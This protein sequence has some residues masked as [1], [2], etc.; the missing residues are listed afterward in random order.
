MAWHVT[1]ED[2]DPEGLMPTHWWLV[3]LEYDVRP[4]VMDDQTQEVIEPE[5]P[6]GS[7]TMTAPGTTW[8]KILEAGLNSLTE[9]QVYELVDQNS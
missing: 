5:R 9:E 4:Q 3:R 7:W 8:A 2:Q 6:G 1:L